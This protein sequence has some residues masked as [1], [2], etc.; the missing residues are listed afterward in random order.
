M[1]LICLTLLP[2]PVTLIVKIRVPRV[3]RIEEEEEEEEIVEKTEK[4]EYT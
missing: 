3:K 4:V 1:Y 2:P